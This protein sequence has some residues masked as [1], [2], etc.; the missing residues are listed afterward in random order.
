MLIEKQ[1]LRFPLLRSLPASD[2]AG[3][4]VEVSWWL[5]GGLVDVGVV[6]S[7]VVPDR[8]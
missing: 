4:S 5:R 7:G 3:V 2:T 8:G 6:A 1:T